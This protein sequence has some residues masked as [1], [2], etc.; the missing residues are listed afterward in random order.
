[1]F[2]VIF[3]EARY[4]VEGFG[5]SSIANLAESCVS[6]YRQQGF[7]HSSM[8]YSNDAAVKM[9]SYIVSASVKRGNRICLIDR[10]CSPF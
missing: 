9:E 10:P 7:V 2:F 3:Y 1:V 5:V 6:L 4:F 8:S